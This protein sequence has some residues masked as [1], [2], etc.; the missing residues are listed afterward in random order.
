[1]QVKNDVF[2][3]KLKEDYLQNY[4]KNVRILSLCKQC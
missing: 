1:M 2:F 3:F 4:I